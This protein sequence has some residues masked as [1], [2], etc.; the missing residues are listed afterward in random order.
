MK[1]SEIK[2]FVHR[3]VFHSTHRN[4]LATWLMLN[5]PKNHTTITTRGI[6]DIRII[7]PFPPLENSLNG[8]QYEVAQRAIDGFL[9]GSLESFKTLAKY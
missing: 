1:G 5:T 9:Y 2:L 3:D 7:P 4:A 8:L 6:D